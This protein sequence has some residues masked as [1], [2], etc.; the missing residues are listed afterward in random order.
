MWLV[1]GAD[2]A[3][4]EALRQVVV[5]LHGAELPLATDDVFDDEIDLRSVEGGFA[6]LFG[7]VAAE[8]G[9]GGAQGI[10]C[11]VPVGRVADV[12]ARVRVAQADADAVVL[13]AE[14]F[15]DDFDEV[16]AADDLVLDLFVGAEQVGVVLGEAA[17]PGHAA[18]LAGFLPAVDGAE[19][20]EADRQVAVAVVVAGVDLDVV[21]AVHRL[22]HE[23][24]DGALLE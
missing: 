2:V 8:G 20:G 4:V 3:E 23:A 11:L 6:S 9:G 14:R 10:L 13:H 17:H 12:L 24:V 18:E 16:E 5:D 15:E 1:V 22:E 7:E 21:R 19:L